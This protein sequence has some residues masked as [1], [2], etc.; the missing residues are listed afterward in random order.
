[1]RYQSKEY[2]ENFLGE[3]GSFDRVLEVGSADV[4]GN[5]R[6]LFSTSY[7]LGIDLRVWKNV[8]LQL[9][10][11]DLKKHFKKPSFDLVFYFDTLEHD[12][13]FWETVEGMRF[14]LKPKG[15]MII[16]VPG[17]HAPYHNPEPEDYWRFMKPAVATFFRDFDEVNITIQY[18][19]LD[20][21]WESEIIGKGRKK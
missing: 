15:W 19:E 7:Y 14:V 12:D 1:M 6:G 20:K 21:E 10:G 17:R 18:D 8:D 9:N 3:H 5:L 16:G 2:M 13:K 11:H 4:T